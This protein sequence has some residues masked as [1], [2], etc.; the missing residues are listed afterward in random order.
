MSSSI[1]EVLDFIEENAAKGYYMYHLGENSYMYMANDE[2]T[3]IRSDIV[4]KFRYYIKYLQYHGFSIF[5]GPSDTLT[6]LPKIIEHY[7]PCY[8][9]SGTKYVHLSVEP[10]GRAKIC[11]DKYIKYISHKN[12]LSVEDCANIFAVA[13]KTVKDI[14]VDGAI[15][16]SKVYR[17]FPDVYN[18]KE[19]V[20]ILG[21]KLISTDD[22]DGGYIVTKK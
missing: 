11:Y 7:Q 22:D 19:Y 18:W 15:I 21:Y 6:F 5:V 20:K 1:D 17:N 8:F 13:E 9:S 3:F 10:I 14:C 4:N 12:D 2:S 16:N